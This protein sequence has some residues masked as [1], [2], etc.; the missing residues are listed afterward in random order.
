V[1]THAIAVIALA[2]LAAPGLI[3]YVVEAL[4]RGHGVGG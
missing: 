1:K 4:R 3:S 2:C